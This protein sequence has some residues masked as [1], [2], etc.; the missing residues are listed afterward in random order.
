MEFIDPETGVI[1]EE[2][3]DELCYHHGNSCAASVA[4]GEAAVLPSSQRCVATHSFVY[5]NGWFPLG[6]VAYDKETESFKDLGTD[7]IVAANG[8]RK[9]LEG[10]A[11]TEPADV[12]VATHDLSAPLLPNGKRRTGNHCMMVIEK[13]VVVRDAAG[14]I[15]PEESYII[16]QD[17]WATNYEMKGQ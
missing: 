8:D 5:K 2:F 14:Q 17:Q 12:M 16:V 15:D 9:V 1:P 13:P 7:E 3:V 6:D 10:Y 4:W 11:L